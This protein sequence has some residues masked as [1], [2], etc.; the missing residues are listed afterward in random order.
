MCMC[1]SLG[2]FFR[3]KNFL[4]NVKNDFKKSVFFHA[5]TEEG[6]FLPHNFKI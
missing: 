5:Q 6:M 1:L 3:E 2:H 4:V